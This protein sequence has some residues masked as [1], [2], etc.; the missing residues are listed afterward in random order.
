MLFF[1]MNAIFRL[2]TIIRIIDQLFKFQPPV[3]DNY[4]IKISSNNRNFHDIASLPISIYT[5]CFDK[6]L[7]IILLL[8]IF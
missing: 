5:I 4:E 7:P 2:Y 6:Y 8:F 1:T 3:I